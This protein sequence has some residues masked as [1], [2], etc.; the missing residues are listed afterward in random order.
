MKKFS[1]VPDE[2]L[3]IKF[4]YIN[5]ANYDVKPEMV[6]IGSLAREY[7]SIR[8][9]KTKKLTSMYPW[10]EHFSRGMPWEI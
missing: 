4:I 1:P 8:E 3:I 2:K 7:C 9:I 6:V 10:R 5:T